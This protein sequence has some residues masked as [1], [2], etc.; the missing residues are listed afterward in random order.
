MG[1]A[2]QFGIGREDESL[3]A[4]LKIRPEAIPNLLVVQIADTIL[5]RSGALVSSLRNYYQEVEAELNLH[6]PVHK[7]ES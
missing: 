2:H 6:E 4:I 7:S 5:Q 3:Q 1:I